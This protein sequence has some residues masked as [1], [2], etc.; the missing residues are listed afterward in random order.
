ML[1]CYPKIFPRTLTTNVKKANSSEHFNKAVTANLP[2]DLSIA[3]LLWTV[4]QLSIKIIY[5]STWSNLIQWIRGL[6]CQVV[7]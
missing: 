2:N 1:I 3:W 4:P 6:Y 5:N 7:M